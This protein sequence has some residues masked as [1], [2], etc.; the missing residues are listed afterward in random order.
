[1][2]EPEEFSPEWFDA[3]SAAWHLNKR[4]V[5]LS[6]IY[7]CSKPKCTNKV[8]EANAVCKKHSLTKSPAALESLTIAERVMKRR[9][10]EPQAK[11]ESRFPL[12]S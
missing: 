12:Y 7:V 4:R 10:L 3:S 9:R 2:R 11:I 6:Y 5:G 8:V 1:M